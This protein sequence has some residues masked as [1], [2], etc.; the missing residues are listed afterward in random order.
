MIDADS[1]TNRLFNDRLTQAGLD[2]DKQVAYVG[3]AEGFDEFEELF[4][5]D[6]WA[7]AANTERCAS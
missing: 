3:Q 2:L 6:Q 1:T 4:A 7:H 5:D